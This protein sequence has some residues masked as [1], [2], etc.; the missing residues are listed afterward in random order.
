MILALAVLV[1][2]VVALIRYG[3]GAFSRIAGIPLRH[4]WLVLI[5]VL[6]QIPLLRTATGP[7]D[8]TTILGLRRCR[9]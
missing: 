5:A 6:L 9:S 1:G 3:R 8:D 4:A 7:P 2:V